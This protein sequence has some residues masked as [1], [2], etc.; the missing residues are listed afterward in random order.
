MA[1]SKKVRRKSTKRM[2]RYI[3]RSEWEA[4][5]SKHKLQRQADIV[6]QCADREVLNEIKQDVKEIVKWKNQTIGAA[7]AQEKTIQEFAAVKDWVDGMKR[8][9]VN[10]GKV[11]AYVVGIATFWKLVVEPIFFKIKGGS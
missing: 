3:T 2:S 10:V 7:K 9:A 4:E 5:K 11:A 8:T 6:Q 1:V